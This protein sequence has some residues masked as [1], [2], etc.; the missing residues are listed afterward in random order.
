MMRSGRGNSPGQVR[1]C[2]VAEA[3]EEEDEKEERENVWTVTVGLG[4]P[5][6]GYLL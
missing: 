3:A 2:V 6:L 4:V 5:G 1:R